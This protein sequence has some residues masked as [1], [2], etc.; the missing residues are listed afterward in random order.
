MTPKTSLARI[1]LAASA[2]CAPLVA[3]TP[4]F[5]DG[6][7]FGGSKVFSEGANPLGNPARY[8]QAQGGYYF[9]FLN[10]DQESKNTESILNNTGPA[11][12]ASLA[13]LAN[14]PWALRTQAYGFAALKNGGS[15]ALT[16]E[17]FNSI[18]AYPDLNAANLGTGIANNQSWLDGRRATVDRLSMGM[19]GPMEKGSTTSLGLSLRVERWAMG[20]TIQP[21]IPFNPFPA[22][23]STLLGTTSTSVDTWNAGLDAG[24]VLELTQGVR[25]GLTADQLNPKHLWDVYLQPRFRA[26]LQLDLGQAAKNSLEGDLNS[27]ERMP[28]PVK[29]QTNSASLR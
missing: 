25:L 12:P 7:A 10:G 18:L 22:A 17:E 3:Q 14:A 9:T 28:F 13:Q 11:D 19:G 8:G 4:L 24:A 16:R 20:E 23:T 6:P 21:Y 15:L 1:V 26:G 5:T 27:V 29:Q 2:V